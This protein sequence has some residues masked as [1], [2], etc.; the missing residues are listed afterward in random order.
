MSRSAV[1]YTAAGGGRMCTAARLV[2][3]PARFVEKHVFCLLFVCL[4]VC[5]FC[6]FVLFSLRHVVVVVV[7]VVVCFLVLFLFWSLLH[8]LSR[9]VTPTRFVLEW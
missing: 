4:F 3:T 6:L 7:V 1:A 2:S 8:V 5:L 9:F